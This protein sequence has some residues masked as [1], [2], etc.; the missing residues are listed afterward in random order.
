[1]IK[2]C[3]ECG[4]DRFD[5]TGA[6]LLDEVR[7]DGYRAGV[8]RLRRVVEAARAFVNGAGVEAWPELR[9]AVAALEGEE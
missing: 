3:L 4:A 8:E 7:S 1:M 2:V 5:H 9:A 6:K